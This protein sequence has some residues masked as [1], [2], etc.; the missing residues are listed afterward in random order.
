[1]PSSAKSK[2]KKKAQIV[3]NKPSSKGKAV[4]KS[5]KSRIAGKMLVAEGKRA[6]KKAPVRKQ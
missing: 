5:P 1:M 4:P 6:A 3:K 2:P